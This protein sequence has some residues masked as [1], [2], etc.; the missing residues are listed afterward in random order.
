MQQ[1]TGFST[2]MFFFAATPT[3][4]SKCKFPKTSR[5]GLEEVC[6]KTK[7]DLLHGR[8]LI[9]DKPVQLVNKAVETCAFPPNKDQHFNNHNF[10]LKNFVEY[11]N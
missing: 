9:L 3:Y 1:E 8:R 5:S 2:N 4:F 7:E 6:A 11:G 10:L